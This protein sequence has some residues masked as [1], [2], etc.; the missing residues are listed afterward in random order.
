MTSTHGILNFNCPFSQSLDSLQ[1]PHIQTTI[2]QLNISATLPFS[3]GLYLLFNLK[4]QVVLALEGLIETATKTENVT[5]V[6]GFADQI[7]TNLGLPTVNLSKVVQDYP[8]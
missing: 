6:D 8:V 4:P 5:F 1:I 7:S 2:V 3:L